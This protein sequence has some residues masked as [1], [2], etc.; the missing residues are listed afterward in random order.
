MH[1]NPYYGHVLDRIGNT[2]LVRLPIKT[3][4]TILGK[5]EYFNPGG[6]IKDRAAYFM[7]EDAEKRGLLRP[8]GTIIEASSGNQG[9]AL[10]MIGAVKGYNVIITVPDKT[11]DEKIATLRSYGARVVVCPSSNDPENSQ[12]YHA[13]AAALLKSIENS[14]MPNQYHNKQNPLSHYMTTGP[15]LWGQTNGTITHFIAA[16]GSCGTVSGTGKYLKEQNPAIKIIAIDEVPADNK[17]YKIEG[18]GIGIDDNLDT[19]V[20]DE[21]ILIEGKDAFDQVKQF[22]T[23]HGMLFGLSSGAVLH[24]TLNYLNKLKPTDVVVVIIADSGRAY[25]HKLAD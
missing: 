20:V 14:Y 21:I 9:I 13:Q 7:I 3:N 16:K 6:S 1:R 11:S 12:G 25:L 8:G 23:Q 10:A 22:A 17:P 15:E 2:P 19:S 4:A 5:L 18:I 24:A